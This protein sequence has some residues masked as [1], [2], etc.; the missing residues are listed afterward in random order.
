[1]RRAINSVLSQTFDQ[2]EL[3]ITDDSPDESVALLVER[4]FA[5]FRQAQR[6]TIEAGDVEPSPALARA[7]PEEVGGRLREPRGLPGRNGE[8][9]RLQRRYSCRVR[10]VSVKR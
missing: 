5:N 1:M 6:W 2:Y 9:R 10:G 3:I 8:V 4:E 7:R